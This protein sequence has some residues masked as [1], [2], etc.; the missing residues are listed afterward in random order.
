MSNTHNSSRWLVATAVAAAIAGSAVAP[1]FAAD[2]LEE[3]AITGSRIQRNRDLEAASPI[4][5][6]STASLENSSTVAVESVLQQ[7]PQ[8][9][10]GGNQFVSGAQAGAA[11]TP[12]IATLNLSLIHI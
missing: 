7:L 5:T 2:D 8:F 9:V 1:A 11:Q 10:P 12:G 6:V 4:V 3:V